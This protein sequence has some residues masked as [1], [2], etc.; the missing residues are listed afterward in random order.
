MAVG[1]QGVFPV[2]GRRVITVLVADDEPL[3]RSGLRMCLG[4]EPD[5]EVVGLASDGRE[6]VAMAEWL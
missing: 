5:F 6:A 3:L 2:E 4:A 1:I